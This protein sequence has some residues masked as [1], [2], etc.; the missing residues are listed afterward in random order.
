M[1][2]SASSGHWINNGGYVRRNMQ[3]RFHS[4]DELVEN[5]MMSASPIEKEKLQ[6][7]EAASRQSV[8]VSGGQNVI[9]VYTT[10]PVTIYPCAGHEGRDLRI[11]QP[12]PV[13]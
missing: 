10:G 4:V 3:R 1:P 5:L 8:T 11:T 13:K 7:E 9:V 2:W 6:A 12:L